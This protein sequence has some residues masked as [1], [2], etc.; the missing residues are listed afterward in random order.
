MQPK[1]WLDDSIIHRLKMG[2]ATEQ[3]RPATDGVGPSVTRTR[4]NGRI[5][6]PWLMMMGCCVIIVRISKCAFVCSSSAFKIF[7]Y[8]LTRIGL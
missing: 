3:T 4:L 7:T 1:T 5:V 6:S 8:L 2:E